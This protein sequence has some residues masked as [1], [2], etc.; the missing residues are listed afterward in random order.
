LGVVGQLHIGG[1]GLARGYLNQPQ[2]SAEKFIDDPFSDIPEQKIY[3]TGD[4]VSW[5]ADGQLTYKGRMD[6]QVKIRGFR[7]ELGEIEHALSALEA[8]SDALVVAKDSATDSKQLVA[9]I[10]TDKADSMAKADAHSLALR[11]DFITTLQQ[12]LTQDLP[13]YMVPSTFVF[14]AQ[15]P[16]TANGKVARKQLP[17]PDMSAQQVEQIEPTTDTEK[18]LCDVFQSLLGL[19]R[20]GITDDFFKLGGH[21]LLAT[22]LI[23][24][25]TI[26]FACELPLQLI[27]EKPTVA[28]IAEHLLVVAPISEQDDTQDDLLEEVEL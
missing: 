22:Q 21:S 16:L 10:V 19:S 24:R 9:Y 11:R 5:T 18:T 26:E 27:F 1:V 28:Q 3:Q 14:L 17:A 2:M 23:S 4:L 25:I 6:Y 8:V 20:V 15:W 7:I 13:E 12:A